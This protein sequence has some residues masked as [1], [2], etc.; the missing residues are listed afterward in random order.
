[1]IKRLPCDKKRRF[2]QQVN[3]T[4]EVATKMRKIM[5]RKKIS[6]ARAKCPRCGKGFVHAVLVGPKK[7]MHMQCD[8]TNC[9]M[10]MQ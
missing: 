9:L 4:I 7:H 5:E 6:R 3:E 8:T 1:M 10:M 2:E